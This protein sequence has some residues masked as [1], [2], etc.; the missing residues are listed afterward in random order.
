MAGVWQH[1]VTPTED[2][3][4]KINIPLEAMHGIKLKTTK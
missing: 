1:V 3:L 4:N 2:V